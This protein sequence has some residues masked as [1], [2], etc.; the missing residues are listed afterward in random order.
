MISHAITT[1]RPAAEKYYH[2]CWWEGAV[3]CHHV[4]HTKEHHE[5]FFSAPGNVFLGNLSAVQWRLLTTR[6]A[7]FCRRQGIVLDLHSGRGEHG[8]REPTRRRWVTE[9]DAARLHALLG[10]VR[11]LQSELYADVYQHKLRRL[12]QSANVVT[13]SDVP[14]DVV[15]MNSQVRLRHEDDDVETDLFLVFPADARGSDVMKP[16]LS[17]FTQTGLSLLGRRVGDR[18]DDRLRILDLPYQ[19]EA[20]GDYDL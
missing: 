2:V 5:V 7:D 1:A 3:Q 15:T 6:I 17:I 9:F 8:H 16:K 12:L 4:R 13:P 20:A 19:P 10:R 18:I 11:T 14:E